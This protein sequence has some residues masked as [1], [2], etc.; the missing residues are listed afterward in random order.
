MSKE[1]ILSNI[2]SVEETKAHNIMGCSENWYNPYYALKHT[3]TT[4]ELEAMSEQELNDLLKIADVLSEA[5]Y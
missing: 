2:N 4:E 3:F 5:F 1:E